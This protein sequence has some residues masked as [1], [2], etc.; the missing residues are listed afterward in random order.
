M[1]SKILS[2][3]SIVTLCISAHAT[4]PKKPASDKNNASTQASRKT[5]Q[6]DLDVIIY[7]S[8]GCSYCTSVKELFTEKNIPYTEKNVDRNPLLLK[9]LEDKTG[10][11]TVPQIVV[12]GKHIG[13]YLDVVW[14]DLEQIIKEAKQDSIASKK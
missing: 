2:A 9:E 8:K 7:T 3:L 1:L 4:T 5:T 14:G 6:D 10:K 12:N 11:K 13:S